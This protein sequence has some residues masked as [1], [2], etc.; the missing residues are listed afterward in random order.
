M[1]LEP[2]LTIKEVAEALHACERTVRR[3][4]NAGQL[5]AVRDGRM[6]KVRPVDLRAYI[7]A[8]IGA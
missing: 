7:A 2:L 5:L 8:R 6:V 1:P 3:R 4:I